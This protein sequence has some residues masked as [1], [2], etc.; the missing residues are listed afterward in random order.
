MPVAVNDIKRAIKDIEGLNRDLIRLGRRA[1][2]DIV[3][4]YGELLVWKELKSR[5][6][7]QGYKIELGQGQTRAGIW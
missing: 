2:P 5:F 3:G 7:W 6:G 1:T 4:F